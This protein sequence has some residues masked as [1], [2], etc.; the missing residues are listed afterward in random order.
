MS[1]LSCCGCWRGANESKPNVGGDYL[2]PGGE[3]DPSVSSSVRQESRREAPS[4]A[5]QEPKNFSTN[6]SMRSFLSRTLRV[7]NSSRYPHTHQLDSGGTGDGG[8]RQ[9]QPPPL[10]PSKTLPTFEE[11]KLLKTVGKG[12]FG[13]VIDN[14]F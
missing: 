14:S 5:A 12:A 4:G 3:W 13:K 6:R 11:F 10:V 1:G 9:Y 7:K 8:K 2:L